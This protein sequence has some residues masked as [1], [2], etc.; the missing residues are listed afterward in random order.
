MKRL[1]QAITA[2]SPFGI[3]V[4]VVL[5]IL[6]GTFLRFSASS[7]LW[8]DEALGVNIASITC[9]CTSGSHFLEEAISL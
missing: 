1:W 6:A 4:V 3:A 2:L 9:F 7:K 8:L 5:D